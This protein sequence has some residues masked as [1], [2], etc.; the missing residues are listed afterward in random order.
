ME[1]EV[2]KS[3]IHISPKIKQKEGGGYII[4]DKSLWVRY[5]PEH[6]WLQWAE[7][8]LNPVVTL[9]SMVVIAAFVSWSMENPEVA[10]DEFNSWKTWIG[11][12]FTWLYIGSQDVW[13]FFVVYIFFSRF[14]YLKL[15][16]ESSVPEYSNSSWFAMLFSCGVSTGLFFFGVAEPVNHY[17]QKN[18]YSADPTMPDNRLAQEA[19]NI[20]F[21]NWG[22]HGWVV[23]TIVGLLVA[24]MA[25]R[26]GL[27]MTVKSCFY[28]L[29]G[30]KIFGWPGDLVDVLSVI[31][32]LF[33]VCTSLGLGTIQINE[34]LH[35]L[36]PNIEISTKSQVIIIWC[37]TGV[38]TVS[39]LTGI[40]YGIRRLS[41]FCF[42]CGMVL[43]LAVLF[44]DDTVFLLNLYTQSIGFYFQYLLQIGFHSDAFEQLGPS[45]GAEDRGRFVPEG[46]ESTDGP[47]LWMGWWTIF[48]WG[49]WIAWCPFVGMF[50]A[51]ISYG[52]TVKEFI[53]GTMAAPALYVF[54]W[55]VVFG[56]S[57]LRMERE[58]ANQNLCCHN[59]NTTYLLQLSQ[60]SPDIQ[61]T[62]SDDLCKEDKCSPC[63]LRILA[64]RITEGLDFG[65]LGL[66]IE[67]VGQ[68]NWGHTHHNR[69]YTRLSCRET[70]QMWFDM[71]MSYG[72]IG[73]FLSGFSLMSLVLYFVTSSDSGSLVID[74]LASNG[75]PE[76]PQLQRV[77][78]A[79]LE[80]LT[81]TSLLVAGGEKALQ[82]LQ[83]VAIASGLVYT[84][85]M[86]IA[87]VAL[88]RALKVAA[89]ETTPDTPTF[90]IDILDPLL[91]DPFIE[92]FSASYRKRTKS[93]IVLLGKFLMNIVMAPY[94]A[95]ECSKLVYG[96][97]YFV[98]T[99]LFLSVTP[100]LAITLLSL[101]TVFDGSWALGVVCYIVFT[102]AISIIRQGAREKLNIPGSPLEDFF[103]S[104]ILYPSV[105]VQMQETLNYS[106]NVTPDKRSLKADMKGEDNRLSTLSLNGNLWSKESSESGVGSKETMNGVGSKETMNGVGSMDT[107][108]STIPTATIMNEL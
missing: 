26:E 62:L 15:G 57:G 78:W 90:H 74:C 75:H 46:V 14:G 34:G 32:T 31:A 80:G 38:A 60:L 27:P 104:V 7:I 98:P 33:G 25:H 76:P 97:S 54:M 53:G 23:Y 69:T 56:G 20:T 68:N 95:A 13:F 94:S 24:L 59:I 63:S 89:G 28:P 19:M 87:C 99:L 83:A 93:R 82:A 67:K 100:S 91:A 49:W 42:C 9:C 84:V 47:S 5:K 73:N 51:K 88:W 64:P 101:Q 71:M 79:V 103:L 96:S 105:V 22:L 8:S 108:T 2:E 85:L 77:F 70:E 6:R 45:H 48:Y 106:V 21:Y 12:N 66:E 86:C 29:I 55:M 30:E 3:T 40:K 81:A 18:R 10:S 52:R 61:L 44:L 58:A 36:N 16:T 107:I 37:V 17:T 4:E 65:A 1:A 11:K 41:E 35:L 39:V 50:I 102:F 92:I 43:M 72:D